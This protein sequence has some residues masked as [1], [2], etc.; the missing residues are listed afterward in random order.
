[1]SLGK[2][3][4][5]LTN[6]MCLNK[7]WK[8]PY[9]SASTTARNS[10]DSG[11]TMAEINTPHRLHTCSIARTTNHQRLKAANDQNHLFCQHS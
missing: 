5:P 9:V 4:A 6:Q 7:D 8:T 2:P 1:M 10:D 11:Q 3:Q